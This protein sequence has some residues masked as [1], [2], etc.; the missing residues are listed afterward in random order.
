[1]SKDG[2]VEE[3]EVEDDEVEENEVEDIK[4]EIYPKLSKAEKKEL[5]ENIS[6][7]LT[8][9]QRLFL[10]KILKKHDIPYD[11][12]HSGIYLVLSNIP[13]EIYDKI[14]YGIK[15]FVDSC[16]ENKILEDERYEKMK[17]A[18]KIL[19]KIPLGGVSN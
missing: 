4:K 5:I 11:K 15:K 6:S 9:D 17:A 1:M 19:S 16:I 10:I 12:N 18:K 13:S 2:V 8:R 3:N 14:L 7:N